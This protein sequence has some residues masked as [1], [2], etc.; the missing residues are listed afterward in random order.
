MSPGDN[1]RFI[2][3]LRNGIDP[4]QVKPGDKLYVVTE[5]IDRFFNEIAPK[6]KN[7][8]TL[9]TSRCDRGTGP[10]EEQ[11]LDKFPNIIQWFSSNNSSDVIQ[12]IPLGLQ[13]KHWRIDN[14]P[15]SDSDLILSVGDEIIPSQS[16][17]LLTFNIHTNAHERQHCYNYFKGRSFVHE[18]KYTQHNRTQRDF[19]AE[20]FR[21]IKKHKFV[22]CPPGGGYD[23]H[24]NWEV[25]SLGGFPI[26][27]KH[28]T[29]EAFYDM[30]A[31]FVDDWEEVTE[32]KID[33]KYNDCKLKMF[34]NDLNMCNFEYWRCKIF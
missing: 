31:W 2:T 26:I 8:Y 9:I 22:I 16:S 17:V 14:H 10:K 32:D 1:N 24:R 19:V 12:T 28:K 13:N 23:C 3:Q 33:E 15:Q 6:I 20:Y 34:F 25:W 21:Q 11:Y 4:D 30:P 5:Y 29:M 27:K 18:R 7:E